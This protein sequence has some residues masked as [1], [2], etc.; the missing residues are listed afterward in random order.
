MDRLCRI[1]PYHQ[2]LPKQG[3]L[4][5]RMTTV[6]SHVSQ[7]N[8]RWWNTHCPL[9]QEHLDVSLPSMAL[10]L[11]RIPPLPKM[12]EKTL[13]DMYCSYELKSCVYWRTRAIRES[14]VRRSLGKCRPVN[15][16]PAFTLRTFNLCIAQIEDL[17]L[18]ITD[19]AVA[20]AVA[21]AVI[22]WEANTASSGTNTLENLHGIW[23][24]SEHGGRDGT[25]HG[26][27]NHPHVGR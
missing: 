5:C 1:S 8:T 19:Y 9:C 20:I 18:P 4:E 13:T 3:N 22:H 17:K 15:V 21:L 11:E 7:S 25:T 27:G 6:C 2:G 12:I 24:H 16:L 26:P 23:P 14:L 10:I